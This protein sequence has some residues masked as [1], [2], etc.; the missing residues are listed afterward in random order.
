MNEEHSIALLV[1]LLV[2]PPSEEIQVEVAYAL[3]CVV[4]GNHDNQEKLQEESA[5][6]YDVLF[7]LLQH[8]SEVSYVQDVFYQDKSY[9]LI[10]Q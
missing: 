7:D 3:G 8:S 5:F 4:L 1:Q 6:K 2:A 10:W 9:F